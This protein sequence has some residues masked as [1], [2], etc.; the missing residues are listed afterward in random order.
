M[1]TE[2]LTSPATR[3]WQ[4]VYAGIVGILTTW[5]LGFVLTPEIAICAGNL[6]AFMVGYRR[7]IKL[8]FIEVKTI[9]PHTLEIVMKSL[10]PLRFKPGQ[11][12]E[13]SLPHSHVDARGIR[14]TFSI[15]SA[16][17]DEYIR[18]GITVS[19][20]SSTLKKE[21]SSLKKGT[22]V[23]AT[24]LGGDFVL[25]ENTEEPLL[26]IAGGIGITP[27]RAIIADL[28][29]RNEARDIVIMHG[30]RNEELLVYKDVVEDARDKLNIIYVPVIAEPGKAWKGATG[31]ITA[32]SIQ[33]QVPDISER[34]IYISGPSLMVDSIRSQLIK[35]GV[36]RGRIVK[37]YFSGY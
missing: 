2:P 11:Y 36:K 19:D 3:K 27:F 9:A 30:V 22:I 26:F 14:R 6:L 33:E 4:I 37:D 21:L 15:A 25:S 20:P 29:G 7:S 23:R 10:H 31:F 12:L 18:F 28:V 5:Q 35:S 17:Q 16:P 8:E 34:R 32:K 1:L 24:Q 13:L